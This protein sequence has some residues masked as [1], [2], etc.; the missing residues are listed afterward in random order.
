[1]KSNPMGMLGPPPQ[2]LNMDKCIT[3]VYILTYPYSINRATTAGK[4]VGEAYAG[5]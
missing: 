3:E 4:L 2:G 5:T 1:M